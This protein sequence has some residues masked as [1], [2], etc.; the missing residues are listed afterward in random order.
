MDGQVKAMAVAESGAVEI[1][2]PEVRERTRPD[3][4]DPANDWLCAWCLNR[5]ASEKDRFC[6]EGRS[7]FSFR[8]PEGVRFDI[9]TFART[10]GCKPAGIPTEA[11]TWFPGHAWCYCVC[12]RCGSHLGWH[13][14]GPTEFAGLI[15]DRI[16]RALLIWN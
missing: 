5:V 15:R 10:I 11:Y 4:G 14:T 16:V 9:I 2:E 1:A 8:N 12:D 13:Y 7:E 3:D 6:Y